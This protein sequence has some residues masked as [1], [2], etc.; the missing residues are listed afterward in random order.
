MTTK[1]AVHVYSVKLHSTLDPSF[2]E[3]MDKSIGGGQQQPEQPQQPQP[4]GIL[5]QGAQP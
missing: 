1:R 4:S 3:R 2:K 5:N